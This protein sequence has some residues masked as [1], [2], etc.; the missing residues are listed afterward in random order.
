M[1][2]AIYG[3]AVLALSGCFDLDALVGH[4]KADLAGVDLANA[5]LAHVDLASS[6][7]SGVDLASLSPC[8]GSNLV[9]DPGF[10]LGQTSWTAFNADLSI[11]ATAH[12]GANAL[13]VCHDTAG[14]TMSWSVYTNVAIQVPSTATVCASAWVLVTD[15]SAEMKIS[16]A[17]SLGMPSEQH[18]G[19]PAMVGLSG[20]QLIVEQATGAPANTESLTVDVF[21]G[22]DTTEARCWIVDDVV[23]TVQ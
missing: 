13:K 11:V 5:D 22:M 12:E 8:I 20:W 18:Y 14:G 7:L 1:R 9:P 2:C 15:E 4:A 10:E 16:F 21:D 17:D 6:D 3:L 23:M 19:A